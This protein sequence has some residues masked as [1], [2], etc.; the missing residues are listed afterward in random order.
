M[1][2]IALTEFL[3]QFITEERLQRFDDVLQ[4]R[5]RRLTVVLENIHHAHNASACLRTCDCLGI[6]DVHVVESMNSFEPNRDISLGSSQWLTIRRFQN[7]ASAEH[8]ASPTI[9]CLQELKDNGYRILTTS[10]RQH[11]RSLYDLQADEPTAVVFG[12]EQL[13]VSDEAVEF[14]DGLIHIPMYGFTE[15]FNISV[16]VAL[17]MQHLLADLRRQSDW[18]LAEAEVQELRDRWIRASLGEKLAPLIRRFEA[19]LAADD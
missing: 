15:S 5:T 4:N 18:Q 8:D 9:R 11:S 14:A 10:P 1:T 16:S 6:Q 12:A 2:N 17:V 13:G 7:E 3:A 19:D